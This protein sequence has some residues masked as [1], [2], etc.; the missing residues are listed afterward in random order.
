MDKL[1]RMAVFAVVVAQGSF[2]AA[3]HRLGMSPSAI[4]QHIRSLEKTVGVP[5]LHRSTRRLVLTEAGEA[6]YPGCEAMLQEAQRAEQRLAELR[7]TLV[8]ELR[9]ATTVGI[10]NGPLAEALAPLLLAHPKLMLR[11]LADDRVVDMIEHRVDISLRVNLQLAD[12]NLIAH[13]LTTW[14]LVL[15][16]A[17]RYLSQYGVPETP[18]ELVQHRWITSGEHGFH[19]DLHHQSG[20]TFKLRLAAGQIVSASMNVIRAFTRIGLGISGQPLYEI[21][22]ELRRG[23]L[24]ALLPEWRPAPFRLH[25]LTLERVLPEKTHQALHY[26]RDYFHRHTEK[27][28]AIG[29]DGV[30]N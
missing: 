21:S 16:A 30:F 8:G 3:A 26:L 7:D 18:Q 5:L 12:S 10:G 9:I 6:F 17:P 2:T 23:E 25:A 22:D 11:I 27:P 14:P 28:L 1:N 29:A 4:S 15:C 20:E 13:P 24:I 19:L